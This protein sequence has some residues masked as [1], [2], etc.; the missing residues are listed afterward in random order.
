MSDLEPRRAGVSL[1][2]KE[3]ID[4]A[5]RSIEAIVLKVIGIEGR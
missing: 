3:G 1:Q 2:R 4:D 5:N